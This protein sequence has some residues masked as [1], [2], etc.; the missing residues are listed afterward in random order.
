MLDVA[1]GLRCDS[2]DPMLTRMET[3]L[4]EIS[5]AATASQFLVVSLLVAYAHAKSLQLCSLECISDFEAPSFLVAWRFV[6]EVC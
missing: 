3:F 5:R 6:Q 4:P 2:N 1:Y